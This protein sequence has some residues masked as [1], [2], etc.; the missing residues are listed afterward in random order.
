MPNTT[1]PPARVTVADFNKLRSDYEALQ[2]DVA[3]AASERKTLEAELDHVKAALALAEKGRKHNEARVE[4]L[5][6]QLEQVPSLVQAV[7]EEHP[8]I[9]PDAPRDAY[10]AEEGVPAKTFANQAEL[11]AA[12]KARPGYWF[13]WPPD[14]EA[15]YLAAQQ[16]PVEDAP[17]G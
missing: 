3:D 1:K 5:K 15:A 12:Q 14:A 8:G 9:P 10:A 11:D 7:A 2:K 16:A 17:K 13:A 6:A 4:E